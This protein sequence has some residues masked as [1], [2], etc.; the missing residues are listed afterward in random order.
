MLQQAMDCVDDF[1]VTMGISPPMDLK[2]ESPLSPAGIICNRM[3]QIL[4]GLAH[5]LQEAL[6]NGET[7]QRVLRAHLMIEE[8]GE[9]IGAM[10]NCD[11]VETLDGVADLTYVVVGTAVTFDLPLPA[12]FVEVHKSNMTKQCMPDD[13]AKDRLRDKGP[14]YVPADLKKVLE[15]YRCGR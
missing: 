4:D 2:A 3:S 11:E 15:E 14:D 5:E 13:P 12:A 7:D 9:L 6:E 1:Q 8:L 10:G